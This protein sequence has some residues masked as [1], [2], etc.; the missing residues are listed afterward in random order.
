MSK[1]K[2]KSMIGGA[3]IPPPIEPMEIDEE[4]MNI[5]DDEDGNLFKIFNCG[6][7]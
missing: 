1:A 3:A 4:D 2:R 6:L 7:F 5:S